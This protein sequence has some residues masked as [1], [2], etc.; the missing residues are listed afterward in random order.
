MPA[1]VS[2]G[3]GSTLLRFPR[4]TALPHP[5]SHSSSTWKFGNFAGVGRRT[6]GN[7]TLLSPSP[8]SLCLSLS[9]D[10]ER[11]SE[12]PLQLS[13]AYL[14]NSSVPAVPAGEQK[15]RTA[16]MKAGC[17]LQRSNHVVRSWSAHAC[18]RPRLRPNHSFRRRQLP[19]VVRW[20]L[21]CRTICELLPS[22]LPPCASWF[23]QHG[24][25][26]V[27]GC[28]II[29]SNIGNKCDCSH[30]PAR[31]HTVLCVCPFF[32]SFLLTRPLLIFDW[33]GRSPTPPSP[34]PS[35]PLPPGPCLAEA[36]LSDMRQHECCHASSFRGIRAVSIACCHWSQ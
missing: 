16:A 28:F 23:R 12:A 17:S 24:P 6:A 7:E 8:S 25:S 22:R 11:S 30:T 10:G 26:E 18:R 21:F 31:L 36:L 3:G 2:C 33:K 13:E 1:L 34:P 19:A 4:A 14:T 5:T 29:H 35:P 32:S 20:E 9:L 15:G 27:D